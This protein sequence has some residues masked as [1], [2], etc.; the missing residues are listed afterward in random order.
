MKLL[1]QLNYID[2]VARTGSIRRAA[3]KLNITSTAL[4]RRILALEEELGSPIF[5]RLP[6]G[7][8]LN[9]AG[10]LLIQHI[11]RTMADL[12]KLS[13][14]IADLSG[15]RRGHVTI[16]ANSEIIAGFLPRQIAHYRAQFPEVRFDI[17]RRAPE[18]ALRALR[19]FEADL[20]FIFA[21][22]PPQDLTLL[23]SVDLDV[24]VGMHPTHPLA[25]KSPLSLM[26]CQHYPA[27]MPAEGSG[28]FDLIQ[29]SQRQKGIQLKTIITS[30][31]FEFMAH[32]YRFEQA[33][34]M[35]VPVG[36]DSRLEDKTRLVT[37]PLRPSDQITGRLHLVQTKGRV[38]SVA[39]AKFAE[40]LMRYLSDTY[41]DRII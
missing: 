12:D 37:R 16:A 27:I 33:I 41:P 17:L 20:A 4:N 7:V 13:S 19:E 15:L 34:T 32:Y 23:A 36:D 18:H 11:R 26:D 35:L 38:L 8:R 1:D 14:Q 5:E 28:L 22:I 2:V 9:V 6:H 25:E 40:A 24:F 29:T 39:A 31:S 10:E 30:E 21:P 3:D